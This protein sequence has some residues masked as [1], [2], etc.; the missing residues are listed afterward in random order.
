MGTGVLLPSGRSGEDWVQL[1]RL[2]LPAGHAVLHLLPAPGAATLDAA[3]AAAIS[4]AADSAA[5]S[6]DSAVAAAVDA[7]VAAPVDASTGPSREE[8]LPRGAYRKLIARANDLA[9]T[10]AA[11]EPRTSEPN[12]AHQAVP[13]ETLVGTTAPPA[14]REHG[15]EAAAAEAVLPVAAARFT[16]SLRGGAYATVLLREVARSDRCLFSY[17]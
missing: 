16:F 8:R 5:D 15:T 4:A 17:L 1:L 13:A 10:P 7:S 2:H 9:W 14:P 6:A 11:N 12:A 3:A